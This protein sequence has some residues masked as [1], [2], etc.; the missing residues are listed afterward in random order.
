MIL[1]SS[2]RSGSGGVLVFVARAIASE[3]E[4]PDVL[5]SLSLRLPSNRE[6]GVRWVPRE[7]RFYKA[8]RLEAAAC[9]RVCMLYS[10]LYGV[11]TAHIVLMVTF[12]GFATLIHLHEEL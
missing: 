3:G 6:G 2:P 5:L 11:E 8:A 12:V 10:I 4:C 1:R 7:I 9:S